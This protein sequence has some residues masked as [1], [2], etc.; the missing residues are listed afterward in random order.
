MNP[1]FL[2]NGSVIFVKDIDKQSEIELI[3]FFLIKYASSFSVF[4]FPL[5][6]LRRETFCQPVNKKNHC[7]HIYKI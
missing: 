1:N 3:S 2:T 7:I 5:F 4:S 6:T